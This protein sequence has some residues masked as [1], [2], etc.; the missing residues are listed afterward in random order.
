MQYSLRERVFIVKTYWKTDSL[1]TTQREFRREFHVRDGPTKATILSIA[2]KL[3]TT[4]VLVSESGKHRPSLSAECVDNV[5]RRLVNSP[6]KSLRRLSQETGYSYGTCQRAAKKSGLRPY[7]VHMVQQ[8]K[9]ADHEKRMA[10]CRWFQG[11]CFPLSLT[12]TPVVSSF[13]AIDK[14]VA[15]VGPSRTWNSL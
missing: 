13:L 1:I 15:F 5:R 6:K 4:G 7:R 10:Y 11:L 14:I 12:S 8:L 9:E 3:E 2:R